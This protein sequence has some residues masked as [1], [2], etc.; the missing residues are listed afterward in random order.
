MSRLQTPSRS[1]P[2]SIRRRR[3]RGRR[4]RE[5]EHAAAVGVGERA[6]AV[7]A[8]PVR[9]GCGCS[10]RCRAGSPAGSG[11]AAH[12]GLG[13]L[14][15]RACGRAGRR[16]VEA[17]L[18]ERRRRRP[19]S[20]SA[21]AEPSAAE[22][23]RSTPALRDL[24]SWDATSTVTF[25]P[26]L[27][28]GADDADRAAPLLAGPGRRRGRGPCAAPAAARRAASCRSWP[29]MSLR[30][31]GV[32]PEPVEQTAPCRRAAAVAWSSRFAARIASRAVAR[33]R[34]MPRSA[35]SIVLAGAAAS[36]GAA[37]RAAW[38]AAA[39]ASREADT[40]ALLWKREGRRQILE[41]HRL[42][43]WRV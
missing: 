36:D 31:A 41:R 1:R 18:G 42:R 15:A 4:P 6:D 11:R 37:A 7:R 3:A 35:S 20:S 14:A 34:A 23:V 43:A 9:R 5:V 29:A 13:G 19:A 38:A 24:T 16:R 28:V 33:R 25:G 26:G 40:A 30:R 21:A 27:V 39:T 10:R 8:P 12:Q 17:G 2:A 32:E 22:P